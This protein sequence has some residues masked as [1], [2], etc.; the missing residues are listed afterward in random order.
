MFKKLVLPFLIFILVV[1]IFLAW[2]IMGPNTAFKGEK[3]YLYIKT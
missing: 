1:I 2:K 3:Y